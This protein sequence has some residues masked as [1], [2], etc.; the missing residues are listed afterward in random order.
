MDENGDNY[1]KVFDTAQSTNAFSSIK[2]IS[3]TWTKIT[4]PSLPSGVSIASVTGNYSLSEDKGKTIVYSF[5]PNSNQN[6]A[7][8]FI[9]IFTKDNVQAGS[10][11]H[12]YF[13]T[14]RRGLTM[15]FG[16]Y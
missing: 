8:N 2:N 13:G 1:N 15:I 12:L 4:P 16:L 10:H 9:T 7:Y 5:L 14:Y 6:A 3:S 11:A